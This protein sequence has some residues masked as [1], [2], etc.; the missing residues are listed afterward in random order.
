MIFNPTNTELHINQP[1]TTSTQPAA[2]KRISFVIPVMNE[3]ETL[4][5]LVA[6]IFANVD[7]IDEIE[8][9]FVDDGSPYCRRQ[10]R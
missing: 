9:I 2:A 8:V 3:E 5:E 1:Q 10:Q 4:D 6:G 7:D